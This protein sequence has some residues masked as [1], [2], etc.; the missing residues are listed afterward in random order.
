ML[1]V[2]VN[3]YSSVE[4]ADL[5]FEDRVFSDLWSSSDKKD[6]LLISATQLLDSLCRWYGYPTDPDQKLSFPVDGETTVPDDI[7]VCTYELA[8]SILENNKAKFTD[9]DSEILSIKAGSV[10]MKFGDTNTSQSVLVNNIV[11][12]KLKKYGMCSF[13][14]S[15]ITSVSLTR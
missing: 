10:E 1:T 5:Y 12:S 13:G 6:K 4:D 7:L 9:E 2:G 3:S 15:S 11:R 14:G 8:Y